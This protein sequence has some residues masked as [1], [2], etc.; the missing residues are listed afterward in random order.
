MA[1]LL[2]FGAVIVGVF[3]GVVLFGAP[4]VPTRRQDLLKLIERLDLSL[5]DVLVDCGAGDGLVGRAFA[6][7]I[8]RA[9]GYEINPFLV[10]IAKVA[11]RKYPKNQVRLGDFRRASWPANTTLVYY[12]GAA[13]YAQQ[14]VDK[15]KSHALEHHHPMQ[16]ISYGFDLPGLGEAKS[17]GSFQV[18]QI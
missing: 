4:Y 2:R 8:K 6:K 12:F 10:L 18:Y 13:N 1:W 7:H 17:I 16:I 3:L 5:E 11:N 9:I 15:V 14:L